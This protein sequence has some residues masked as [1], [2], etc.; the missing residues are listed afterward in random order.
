MVQAICNVIR[1]VRILPQFSAHP[2]LP[3]SAYCTPERA[4]GRHLHR[5]PVRGVS[6]VEGCFPALIITG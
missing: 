6:E 1:F 3:E 2:H 4:S 5:A